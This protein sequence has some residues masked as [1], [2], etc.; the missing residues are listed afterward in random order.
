MGSH[1]HSLLFFI[2][3]I[4]F[5]VVLSVAGFE[6]C[7]GITKVLVDWQLNLLIVNSFEDIQYKMCYKDFKYFYVTSIDALVKSVKL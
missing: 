6:Y 4:S 7:T 2:I 3:K 5:S 1:S